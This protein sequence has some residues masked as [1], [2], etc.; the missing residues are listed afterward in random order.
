MSRTDQPRLLVSI[1][2]YNERDNIGKLIDE[3]HAVVPWADVL[4]IDDNSPDGTGNLVDERAAADPRIQVLHRAGKLGLGTAILAGMRYAMQNNYEL[5]LNMDADF[6]HHPRF[7]PAI[8]AGM[9]RNDVMI[10]SRYIPGGGT[11]NWP[12]SRRIM[13]WGV[14][15]IVRLLMRIPAR[16]TSGAYR[17]YR[18]SKLR[19]TDLDAII[20]RGYSFQQEVLWRCRQ[21]GCRISET[22]IFFENRR[23]GASKVNPHEAVR[24]LGTII[25]LGLGAFFGFSREPTASAV[26]QRSSSARG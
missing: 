18:V 2:T 21:A 4:V 1:A 16:D 17:C 15:S 8:L 11:A 13:S 3:I 9:N 5:L 19:E 14:G 10:G 12:L 7:L 26:D 24:S 25:Y 23:A 6:S 22:P 20:S